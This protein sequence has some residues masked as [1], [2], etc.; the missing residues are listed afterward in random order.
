MRE[1]TALYLY[2]KVSSP[3]FGRSGLKGK[4]GL[5]IGV[6]TGTAGPFQILS[7]EYLTTDSDCGT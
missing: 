4:T 5:G 2:I 3:Y 6:M 7:G 1:D